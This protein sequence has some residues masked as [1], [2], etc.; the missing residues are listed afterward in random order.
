MFEDP[1]LGDTLDRTSFDQVY[2][3]H[4]F[5]TVRSVQAAAERFGFEL[6]DVERLPVHGGEVRYT[7]ARS[8]QREPSAAVAE[9]AA[10]E[11]A[12]RLADPAVLERFGADVRRI[13]GDLVSLL[14]GLRAENSGC[15]VA[16]TNISS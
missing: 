14:R 9:L 5:F 1:Y 11:Q 3:E 8:G 10:A 16:S 15:L 12:H 7:V 4:F 6:V 2:D 13:R